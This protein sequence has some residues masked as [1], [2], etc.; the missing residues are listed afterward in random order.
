V[1]FDGCA[2]DPEVTDGFGRG[3][4]ALE[5]EE[6][7][8]CEVEGTCKRDGDLAAIEGLRELG[9]MILERLLQVWHVQDKWSFWMTRKEASLRPAQLA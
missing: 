3:E 8:C 6:P 7:L 4:S 9:T 1:S 5:G 2:P